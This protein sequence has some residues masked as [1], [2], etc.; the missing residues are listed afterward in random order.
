M[1][2]YGI[3]HSES[4][5]AEIEI[6]DYNVYV[7]S[8]IHQYHAEIDGHEVNG[9]EYNYVKYTKDEYIQLLAQ[10]SQRLEEELAATK[11]LLGVE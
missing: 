3:V 2:N 5:P 6:T 1:V 11:I 10:Q 7:A 9:Y 4:S 8:N